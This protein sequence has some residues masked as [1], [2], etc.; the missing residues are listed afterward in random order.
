MPQDRIHKVTDQLLTR[1]GTCLKGAGRWRR[2]NQWA[3]CRWPRA[4]SR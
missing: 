3:D 4:P 1:L 2:L